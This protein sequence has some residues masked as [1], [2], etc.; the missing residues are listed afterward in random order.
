VSFHKWKIESPPG[1]AQNGNIEELTLKK[2]SYEGDPSIE[3]FLKN[4][5]IN[6]RLMICTDQVRFVETEI[7]DSRDIPLNMVDFFHKQG[8]HADPYLRKLDHSC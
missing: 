4:W 3:N 2:E 8:V 7:F 6:P 5:N 1:S